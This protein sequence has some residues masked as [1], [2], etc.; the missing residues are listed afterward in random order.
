[1]RAALPYPPHVVRQRYDHLARWYVLFEWL[2]WLPRGIRGRAVRQLDLRPGD[3]VLEVG[4]GTGRNLRHLRSAVGPDGHVYGV[5][6]SG[7]MLARARRLCKDHGWHNV[8][9]TERDAL[10]YT[11]PTPVDAVLFSLSYCTM[12]HRR[13]ILE[14]AWAQL[15]PGGR[16][17]IL[18]SGLAAAPLRRLLRPWFVWLM[19]ATVLGDPDCDA[20]NDVRALTRDVVVQNELFGSYLICRGRKGSRA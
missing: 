19:K 15:E 7:G 18:D 8:T 13:R 11:P 20:V 1:M 14:H 5:D 12:L 4:C 17:V 6:L 10:S 2:L 9:L 16:L 3:A